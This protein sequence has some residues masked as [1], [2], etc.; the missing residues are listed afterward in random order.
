[1]NV[2]EYGQVFFSTTETIE[3]LYSGNDISSFVDNQQEI[4]KHNAFAKHFEI[5]DIVSSSKPTEN[6]IEFHSKLADTW[7]MPEEYQ[8]LDIETFLAQRLQSLGLTSED[9]IITLSNELKEFKQR[10]MIKL[11]Q[12][13]VYLIDVSKQHDIV[14]G[15]GRGSSVASLVL[16]LIGVHYI[17]PIKYNLNYK[18]FL[19]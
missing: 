15:V 2:N 8:Q 10:K 12:F 17:D 3:H 13:L 5:G 7:H 4:Y 11:L 6:A 18:E 16:Y 1:M 14:T 9:Y 19:R